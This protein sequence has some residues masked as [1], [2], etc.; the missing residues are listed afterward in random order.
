MGTYIIIDARN[1][2]FDVSFDA[3]GDGTVIFALDLISDTWGDYLYFLQASIQCEK[4][5]QFEF[6]NRYLRAAMMNLFAHLDGVVSGVC[7]ELVKEGCIGTRFG[8]NEQEK[9]SVKAKIFAIR[10]YFKLK[11]KR[12]LPYIKLELKP[13]RDIINHPSVTKPGSGKT[14][15][16]LDHVD[17]YGVDIREVDEAGKQIDRWL[18]QVC[19]LTGYQRLIDTKAAIEKFQAALGDQGLAVQD[20]ETKQF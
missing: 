2:K 20:G 13:I 17:V 9:C 6:R 4:E 10:D 12:N 11:R 16:V 3:P 14:S 1:K 19:N 7:N 15:V 5:R 8:D 18:N